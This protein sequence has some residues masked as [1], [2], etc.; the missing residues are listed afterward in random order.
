MGVGGGNRLITVTSPSSL[1]HGIN[2]EP[3]VPEC[4]VVQEI[5]SIE[6]EGGFKHVVVYLLPV[7]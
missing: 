3:D 2:L 6:E 1:S 5:T 7:E 4:S